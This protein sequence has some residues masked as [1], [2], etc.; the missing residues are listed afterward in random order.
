MLARIAA[1]SLIGLAVAGVVVFGFSGSELT[2][3]WRNLIERP[4]GPMTFRFILQPIMAAIAAWRDGARDAQ[5]GR[6]PYLV[7]IIR[8]DGPRGPRLW[9]GVIATSR[10]LLLGIVMDVIYQIT[11]LEAFHPGEAALISILLA[12]VPYLLLRG[13]FRRLA[14][15]TGKASSR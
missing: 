8:G 9:E 11:V 1:A 7:S 10:I 5:L 3:F 15:R 6:P 2:R 13:P 4:G 12:F 14:S